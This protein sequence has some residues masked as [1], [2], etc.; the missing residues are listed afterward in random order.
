[1]D[2]KT[3]FGDIDDYI[4][5][6]TNSISIL[7]D[8]N[9]NSIDT[10]STSS[11]GAR[12]A[13]LSDTLV[14]GSNNFYKKNRAK[15]F[16]NAVI[17]RDESNTVELVN[18]ASFEAI[19]K[20]AE[21]QKE[22]MKTA[23]AKNDDFKFTTKT[24]EQ[25][26]AENKRLANILNVKHLRIRNMLGKSNGYDDDNDESNLESGLD[27]DDFEEGLSDTELNKFEGI[28][29]T[30]SLLKKYIT[31]TERVRSRKNVLNSMFNQAMYN[32]EKS[33]KF[34]ANSMEK[35][36]SNTVVAPSRP[37]TSVS[38]KDD[39]DN[40]RGSK[41]SK[42]EQID[43]YFRKMNNRSAKIRSYKMSQR[44]AQQGSASSEK[45]P[46]TNTSADQEDPDEKNK[47]FQVDKENVREKSR[48]DFSRNYENRKS[49]FK[50]AVNAF[51]TKVEVFKSNQLEDSTPKNS[52]IVLNVISKV[53]AESNESPIS[54][55]NANSSS[56]LSTSNNDCYY[57]VNCPSLL[58]ERKKSATSKLTTTITSSIL[59]EAFIKTDMARIPFSLELLGRNSKIVEAKCLPNLWKN[60]I[61]V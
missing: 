58:S 33:K 43:K 32:Q 59:N 25:I 23:L 14:K 54:S 48:F 55:I 56:L 8:I 38:Y 17:I 36:S 34:Q 39:V 61:L 3:K 16:D 20:H 26:E 42:S 21:S 49:S 50:V 15:F 30:N 2:D 29:K 31:R 53:S 10:I 47:R 57:K 45:E 40:R 24:L 13:N 27:D 51:N 52:R 28:S 37:K 7:Q 4:D 6:H 35:N 22:K 18:K 19:Q 12:Q 1:M 5:T 41:S 60:Y 46:D 11:Y 44:N 9:P